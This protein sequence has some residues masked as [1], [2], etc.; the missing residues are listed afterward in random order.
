MAATAG[1]YMHPAVHGDR[2]VFVCE[3]ALWSVDVGGGTARRLTTAPGAASFPQISPDGCKVAYAAREDGPADVYVMDADGGSSQRLTWTGVMMTA[4]V[5]WNR[6][7][8]GVIFRTNA[9]QPFMG[10]MRLHEVPLD[11]G[12]TREV[13]VGPARAISYEPSGK[14]VVLGVNTGDP[15]RWKRYR[16]GTAGRIWIDRQGDGLFAPL[17][18][19]DGNLG[20]PMWIGKRIFF[21][22]DHE[23]HGNLYSCTPTGR[24]LQRHTHHESYYARFA[25]TDGERIVYHAGA[26]LFV[27]EV[28]TGNTDKI[29]I[30]LGSARDA[31]NRKFVPAA[32]FLESASL[33]PAGHSLAVTTRGGAYTMALWEGAPLRHGPVSSAR[34]RLTRWLQDGKRIVTVSD[35]KGEEGLV[36]MR[37]DGGGRPKR[38]NR[39][40][41]RALDLVVAPAGAERV[42]FHNH[43]QEVWVVD[44]KSGAS[45]KIDA[46][47]FDRIKGLAWSPDGR[48][49]AYGFPVTHYASTI[50]LYDTEKQK[51]HE[52]TRPDFA[53]FGPAFDPGGKYLYFLSLR[54]FDPVYDSQYFDL[55]FPRG[56]QPCL[57]PLSAGEPSPF[58]VAHRAPRAPNGKPD[59]KTTSKKSSTRVDL[60]G[61]A[62]RVVAFPVPEGRYTKI[63]G[64]HRRA[65][66]TVLPV[67]GSLGVNWSDAGEP[68]AKASLQVHRFEDQKTD[69]LIAGVTS[70][71]LAADAK[72]LLARVG[73]RLRVLP[74]SADA[75]DLTPKT[76]AGRATG[77]IDLGRLRA[78]VDPGAEWQQM[79]DEAWRL[80]RDHFWDA[81]MSKIDWN[82]VHKRYR[83]LVGR[84]ASRSEFS[85]LVWEMQGELGTSHCYEMGGD[86]RPVP[87]WYQG[88]L[89]ADIEYSP[90]TKQWIVRRIP[91]GD[92]W[93]PGARSPLA[94]PGVD[95]REGDRILS[96]DGTR[97]SATRSPASCLV[98]QAGRA[99]V[100]EIQSRG[101]K[102]QVTVQ[103]LTNEM[104]LRYRDWVEANRARVHEATSGR[105]GYVHV[106]NMG[107]VGYSEFHRYYKHEFD[108]PG[109]IV[110]VRYNGGGHVSQLLLEKLARKR[111]GYGYMRWM[112]TDSYPGEAPMGPM[113][114]LT[115]EFAGSDGDIF[116]H[117][118]KLMGLGPLIGKRTWGGVVGIWPRHALVDG[119]IT[120]QAEFA[121]W[122]EDVGWG[123]ENYGTDPDIDVD[124]KPQD[125]VAG[126]DPQLDR[127]LVEIEKIIKREKPGL[128][129]FKRL[130]KLAPPKLPK[131]PG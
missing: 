19:L 16:G 49:L 73:N 119:T 76:D 59:G 116:S 81:Q 57:V 117:S 127:A 17:I 128:P 93:I 87:A 47:G 58:E 2:I 90:R 122:F 37:A 94:M 36:V 118:F 77:W 35:E 39:D 71:G 99:V 82:D 84:V 62:D 130:P 92:S 46:S 101:K 83:P 108:R 20:A 104:P 121:H 109:L 32:R 4:P 52:I 125:W 7:G 28:A 95:V 9:E 105:V 106:P 10:D 15:A 96:I 115:N 50:R 98:N 42:A 14:G 78:A 107:P 23:G 22:S 24:G 120:T 55:G 6:D 29:A 8:S 31:R 26:D 54:S 75:K 103:T 80:Q 5:G 102:R 65:F 111:I 63:A 89:G 13:P 3:E 123:V 66:F 45:K 11:G 91:R 18:H 112:G 12:P 44:C 33:H 43:R 129:S 113:V 124:I 114:A 69:T 67:E 64:G 34:Q 53:D 27:Y 110:D 60:A 74:A 40:F 61:M 131:R 25:S 30:T 100:L 79:F 38:I 97:L 56:V 72:T 88:I 85:D 86:Y 126:V 51:T 70:F 41:G 21:I 1:Y 68:P 48:W